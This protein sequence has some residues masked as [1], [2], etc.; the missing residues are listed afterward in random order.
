[1]TQPLSIDF[2]K[3]KNELVFIKQNGEVKLFDPV[4]KKY[5]V[6]GPEEVVRQLVLLFL[7]KEKKYSKNRMAVEKMLKVNGRPKRFDILVYDTDTMPLMLVECKA[8]NVPV[9]EDVFRQIA[10]YNLPLRVKYLLV[11]NGLHSYCCKMDYLRQSFEFLDEVPSF[12]SL[13]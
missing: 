8:P 13:K 1:M 5:L 3:Y 2:L 4:R 12:A 10:T 11:T 7:I 9:T 6:K